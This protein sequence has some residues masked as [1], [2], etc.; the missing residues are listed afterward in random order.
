MAD[1]LLE[2]ARSSAIAYTSFNGA[3][4][5]A[6][7]DLSTAKISGNQNDI[8]KYQAE[9]NLYKEKATAAKSVAETALAAAQGVPGAD[10]TTFNAETQAN[11]DIY[12]TI[13][14]AISRENKYFAR[15]IS[16]AEAALTDVALPSGDI[17]TNPSKTDDETKAKYADTTN[18]IPVKSDTTASAGSPPPPSLSKPSSTAPKITP[19]TPTFAG[20]KDHRVRLKVPMSYLVGQAAGPNNTLVKSQGIIFPFTPTIGQEYTATYNSIPITHSNYNQYFYKNSSVSAISLGAKFT[21]QN[22]YEAE[23]YFSILHLLRALTK[24]RWGD[25]DN[26]GSPPPVCRLFAYGDAIMN[27]VPVAVSSVKID[28]PDNVDYFTTQSLSSAPVLSTI[29]ITL[30]P[31][32]SRNEIQ[33]FTVSD[34]LNNNTRSKGYL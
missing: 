26:A 31:I 28:F 16:D 14:S 33:Q 24:M 19:A 32:Y 34:Y 23:V 7:L 21:V 18:I 13:S 11:K 3:L 29:S 25:D 8:Q 20:G 9:I 10:G 15:N 5:V 27:N 1:P 22:D 2:Q 30:T 12:S 6:L 17:P 4:Q